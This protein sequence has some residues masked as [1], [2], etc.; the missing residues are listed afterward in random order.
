MLG[1]NEDEPRMVSSARIEV[2]SAAMAPRA[3]MPSMK[4]RTAPRS[5][6]TTLVIGFTFSLGA[7][8]ELLDV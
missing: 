6:S 4:R 2:T 3:N 5:G 8:I 7:G 1:V